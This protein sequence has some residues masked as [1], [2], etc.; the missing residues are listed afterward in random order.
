MKYFI[1]IFVS[2]I[3]LS[4][5]GT[6]WREQGYSSPQDYDL[7]QAAATNPQGVEMLNNVGITT[8]NDYKNA[9]TE[10][11]ASGYSKTNNRSDVYWF[12]K[13]RFDG[14]SK[15]RSALDQRSF[16][17]EENLK[18]QQRKLEAERLE[19]KRKADLAEAEQKK[20]LQQQAEQKVKDEKRKQAL[21]AE[22]DR[23]D[24]V[25][26]SFCSQVRN[27]SLGVVERISSQL[28]VDPSSVRFNR[29]NYLSPRQTMSEAGIF[30]ALMGQVFAESLYDGSKLSPT[31]RVTLYSSA[32]PV[33]CEVKSE[34]L[35]GSV[36]VNYDSCKK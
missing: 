4:G 21:Y 24:Q 29:S 13:D 32:G 3:L 2:I 8:P 36:A 19:N 34:H 20:K 14:R 25:G 5:C 11:N 23:L 22:W 26:P 6:P 30:G 28:R 12:S 35:N 33:Y 27:V 10:M 7:A 9:I 17:L 31:C 1:L 18:E 16:R 15:G